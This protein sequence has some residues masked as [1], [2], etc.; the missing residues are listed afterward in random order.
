MKSPTALATAAA[1]LAVCATATANDIGARPLAVPAAVLA[2]A[3]GATGLSAYAGHA[4]FSQYDP[5]T[6]RWRLMHW[7]RGAVKQLSV[8]ERPV[9]FDA[10]AGPGRDGR[11]VAVFSRCRHEP[12]VSGII[13]QPDWGQV[14]PQGTIY[15]LRGILSAT[16][17]VGVREQNSAG[18]LRS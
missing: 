8:G 10:D 6:G 12:A 5:T 7:L 14:R 9:P 18:C 13:A 15:A 16:A 11:P 17:Q 2:P 3:T 1:L 4:V